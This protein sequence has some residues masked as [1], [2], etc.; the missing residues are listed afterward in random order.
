MIHYYYYNILAH[1]ACRRV[2]IWTSFTSVCSFHFDTGLRMGHSA[3]AAFGNEDALSTT[4][5]GGRLFLR[6]DIFTN[7]LFVEAG[8]MPVWLTLFHLICAF[9]RG[10]LHS[11]SQLTRV[12]TVVWSETRC[13]LT[14][15]K[16]SGFWLY[17]HS[18]SQT[19][20]YVFLF[21]VGDQ[22]CHSPGLTWACECVSST[23]SFGWRLLLYWRMFTSNL[24]VKAGGAYVW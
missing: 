9:R 20:V 24:R 15:S 2:L 23:T 7:N 10:Q 5:F 16:F 18:F 4:R 3:N 17:S 12:V 22:I 13:I 14:P 11:V 19:S 21:D 6:K 1:L 8:G